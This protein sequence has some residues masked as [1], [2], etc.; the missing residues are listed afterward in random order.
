MSNNHPD[1][2]TAR[3]KLIMFL[4][5]QGYKTNPNEVFCPTKRHCWVD[6]AAL[7]GQDYWAFE[8]KSRNDSI[9][10]G[11]EQCYAY[12]NAFNYIVLVADRCRVTSSPYFRHFRREGFGV[13]KHDGVRFEQ[14]LPPRRRA[15]NRK[16]K[17]VIERQF[18]HIVP[19]FTD[20]RNRPL[21]N[22][23][24]LGLRDSVGRVQ[25]GRLNGIA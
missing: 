8:Y 15:T 6:V 23:L 10:R 11:L 5:D 22:W 24:E 19:N 14:I 3:R 4:L 12:A 1:Y 21:S 7:R 16:A 18:R 9:R 2:P 25:S 20:E 17:A 13:W